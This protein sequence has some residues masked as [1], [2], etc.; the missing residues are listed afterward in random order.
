MPPDWPPQALPWT[1]VTRFACT[2]TPSVASLPAMTVASPMYASTLLPM[3]TTEMPAPMPTA[4]TDAVPAN[5]W[6]S[7]RSFACT[8]TLSPASTVA[9]SPM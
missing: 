7:M 1:S 2:V 8:P 6:N 4:P 5:E 3:V 9:L